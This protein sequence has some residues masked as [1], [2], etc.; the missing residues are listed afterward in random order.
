MALHVTHKAGSAHVNQ[1]LEERGVIAVNLASGVSLGL[2]MAS[3]DVHVSNYI[4]NI[5]PPIKSAILLSYK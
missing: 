1:V 3:L 5:P 2:L 4:T